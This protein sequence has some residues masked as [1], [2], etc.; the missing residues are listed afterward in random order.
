MVL[1]RRSDRCHRAVAIS[2]AMLTVLV[3]IAR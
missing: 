2:A 1:F 3:G